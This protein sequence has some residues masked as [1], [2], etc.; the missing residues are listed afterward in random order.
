M[1]GDSDE[2]KEEEEAELNFEGTMLRESGGAKLKPY[3]YKLHNQDLYYYKKKD[4]PKEKGMYTLSNVFLR[5]D[6]PTPQDEE[7]KTFVYSFTLIFNAKERKFYSL[8]KAEHDNWVAVVKKAIGYQDILS[9]YE[10]GESIGRGKFGRVKLGVH[11]KT[12]KKVAIKILKKAKMDPEDFELYKREVEILK[13]CQHPNLIRLLDV[14]ENFEYIFIVMEH[15]QG[16]SLLQ[17]FKDK[18]YKLT[19]NRIQEIAHQIAT[20]LFY[21]KSFGIAHRDLKPDNMMM[22]TNDDTSAVKIIDFGL[23]KI[24]GPN[25]RSKD[26]FGTIPYAAPE[27]ILRKPYGHSVDIWSFGVTLFFLVTGFHPFDSE[28]Q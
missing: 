14:F 7:A 19:E 8:K 18:S 28:E 24:I 9:Y 22:T 11:K 1:S 13:I 2:E 27:I 16:G 26:P 10:I 12:Q 25:E 15:L 17:Y 5:E 3:W 20:A 21:L 4:D 6:E 23:S